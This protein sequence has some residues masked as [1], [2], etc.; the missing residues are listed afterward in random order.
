MTKQELPMRDILSIRALA[1][2]MMTLYTEGKYSDAL[3][4]VEQN[5]YRFPE[6]ATR[7]AFWKMCLLS[8]CNRPRDVVS[9][10]QRSLD[11]GLWW[12]ESQFA[13]NDL[14]SVRNLPEFKRL[15]TISQEK[16]EEAR[17][18]IT[19]DQSV[20]LPDSPESGRYPLL[21]VLHGRNGNKDSNIEYWDTARRKGWLVLLVQSTQ[22]LS[23]SSYCWDDPEKAMSDV[24]YYLENISGKYPIDSEHSM[25]AGFSQGSGLAVYA[26]LSGKIKVRGFI[27]IATSIA[28]PKSLRTLSGRGESLHGYFVIGEKDYSL[29]KVRAIQDVLKEKNISFTEELHPELGHEFPRNFEKSFDK[30]IDF[31][32]KEQE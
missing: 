28:D 22:P 12:A 30:A 18:H 17:K 31:I 10:F 6:N 24:I 9:V 26:A 2:E 23:S 16:Y 19:R 4:L 11:S 3:E 25:I 27:G 5:E 29:E 8:L 13:D 21:V 32:F 20:L 7:I 14:D 1:D 15:V